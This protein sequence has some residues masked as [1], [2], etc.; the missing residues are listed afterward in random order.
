[1]PFPPIYTDPYQDNSLRKISAGVILFH[2]AGVLCAI[3]ISPSS[4]QKSL[5]PPRQFVVQTVS[6]SPPSAL[7]PPPLVA[8]VALEKI[9]AIP[10]TVV[11]P[12]PEVVEVESAKETALADVLPPPA[13]EPEMPLPSQVPPVKPK[14][15]PEPKKVE[16][17]IPP[18]PQK[19]IE[20]KKEV[21]A[22]TPPLK[23]P[24]PPPKVEPKKPVPKVEK[25]AA[26]DRAKAEKAAA[27]QKRKNELEQQQKK[28]A[29][30]HRQ[31]EA[32]QQAEKA[33][34]QKLLAQAQE[35][36]AKID[37]NRHK[38]SAGSAGGAN[39]P[40]VPAAI[41]SLQIEAMPAT[42][43][44]TPLSGKELSYRDELAG[45]LKLLLR[46]PEY[47]DVKVKLTLD[48]AG[49][50][51]SVVIISTESAANRK[52]IEKTLPGLT[53]PPLGSNFGTDPQ[54]TFS[55]TLSNE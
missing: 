27:D 21:K 55:V 7:L 34:Q 15:K 51:V 1:M 47:G 48:R 54:Y 14:P 4:A 53:F 2:L 31:K 32:E 9:E 3:F 25:K 52:Y 23:K 38:P 42:L 10:Q 26:E 12:D 50:V 13:H 18:S 20:P 16:K 46:L 17:P 43:G 5:P 49:K 44:G 39:L 8:E 29:E 35:R 6:L 28:A 41:T 19:K 11:E 40:T 45:R 30:V 22:P 36:I 33:R 37:G 24:T